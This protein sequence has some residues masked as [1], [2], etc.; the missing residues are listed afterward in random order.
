MLPHYPIR[1]GLPGF[2]FFLPFRLPTAHQ[3]QNIR[4]PS[5]MRSIANQLLAI[6]AVAIVDHSISSSIGYNKEIDIA[7]DN[8][9]EIGTSTGTS[10]YLRGSSQ[11]ASSTVD[12]QKEDTM[13]EMERL[14]YDDYEG[15]RVAV[16]FEPDVV[17][18]S[19]EQE[20]DPV[21]KVFMSLGPDML[22]EFME[23]EGEEAVD[24]MNM[25]DLAVWLDMMPE[26]RQLQETS[27]QA[28][29]NSFQSGMRFN[30]KSRRELG[31]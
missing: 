13:M 17:A 20:D 16:S 23:Q 24:N 8:N 11:A 27:V 7:F 6:G 19:M 30:G 18:E 9:N 4:R 21:K 22:A 26:T 5:Q 25:E 10:Y 15:D 14:R 29:I 3:K 31:Y 12:Q 28:F 1:F 2:H